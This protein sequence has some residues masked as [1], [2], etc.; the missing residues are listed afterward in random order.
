MLEFLGSLWIIIVEFFKLP[1]VLDPVGEVI[2]HLPVYD[3]EDLGS[4][5][6]KAV[7]ILLEGFIWFL[8]ASS[9]LV[10]STWVGEDATKIF[11]EFALKLSPSINGVGSYL[12]K[13][14]E[15]HNIVP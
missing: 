9:K 13:P 7:I 12:I 10:P 15:R 1:L 14:D 5:F 11:I 6:S 8:F 2:Y 4:Y 3:I